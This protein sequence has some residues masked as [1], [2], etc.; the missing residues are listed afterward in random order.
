M[1]LNLRKTCE[2]TQSLPLFKQTK[3]FTD[4]KLS[5]LYL[6]RSKLSRK[7]NVAEIFER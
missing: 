6:G 4:R 5:Q 7:Q 3:P 1:I 2:G